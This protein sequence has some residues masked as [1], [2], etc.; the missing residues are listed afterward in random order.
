MLELPAN[1]SPPTHTLTPTP[2]LGRF[3]LLDSAQGLFF[4]PLLTHHILTIHVDLVSADKLMPQG[5]L[6]LIL[7]KTELIAAKKFPGNR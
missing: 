5:V 2:K 3:I 4:F 1:K 6:N 7:S